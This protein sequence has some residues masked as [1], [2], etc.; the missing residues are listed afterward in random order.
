M[1]LFAVD[2]S[3]MILRVKKD[4]TEKDIEILK[5]FYPNAEIIIEGSN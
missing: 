1:E 5:E 4:I 2:L 3:N